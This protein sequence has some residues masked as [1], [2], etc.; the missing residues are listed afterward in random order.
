MKTSII[1]LLCKLLRVIGKLVGKG[2]SLPG[3][4][5]LKLDPNILKKIKLPDEIVAVTGSNG[6]TSTVEMIA[7][8]LKSNG[9][10]IAYNKEGSNQIE[11]VTTFLL[12]D[13]T[14]G[15]RVKSDIILMESDERFARHTF[16]HFTPT[17]YVITNLYRDQLTRNG[18]PEWVYDIVGESIHE[19]TH[20]VL[21]ADD[22]LVSCFG[23][24][25]E[26]VTWF[27]VD[28]LPFSTDRN[29]SL[30]HDGRYCPNCKSRME[31][32]YYHYN[33]IGSYHCTGCGLHRNNT[34]YT[35]TDASL[36]DSYIEINGKY[37]IDLSFSGIYHFYNT[38]AT[39]A[40]CNILGIPGEQI[41]SALN[42]YQMKSGRIVKFAVGEKEGTLLTS[43]HENSISYDQSIRVAVQD[44]RDVTV[45][46][47]VDAISRKYFT[48]ETSW[49]WDID[50]ELLAADHVKEIILTGRYCNDLAVRFSYCGIDSQRIHVIEDIGEAVT[51]M[52]DK[53]PGY[54]YV[55]TCFS[56]KEK[57]LEKVEKRAEE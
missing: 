28:R 29:T 12:N 55:I 46:V 31:Y 54:Q 45:T 15:G 4:I 8:V 7:H 43:K 23:L 40:I 32:D 50:F 52:K 16:K 5:A 17:H 35:V 56:D 27:G 10:K 49:L 33:H 21:N 41:V 9:K 34:T 39:F 19:G 20:L 22:P 18:H 2:S 42:G 26:A 11:G 1:I 24:G 6:K 13:C 36:K 51:Y 38:L 3:R 47:I 25:K 37:H 57:L 30:Y 53:A 48:S 14:L 44:E